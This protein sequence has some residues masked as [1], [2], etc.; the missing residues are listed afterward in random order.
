VFA[1]VSVV[2]PTNKVRSQAVNLASGI[3]EST[4]QAKKL[5]DPEG[6]VDAS[7]LGGDLTPAYHSFP[8]LHFDY[9]ISELSTK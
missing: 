8:T 7:E 5:S 1:A 3:S 2:S 6:I 4:G 9:G